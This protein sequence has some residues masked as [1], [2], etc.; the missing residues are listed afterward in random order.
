M[1]PKLKV[2]KPSSN[3]ILKYG[4]KIGKIKDKNKLKD[5]IVDIEL[6]EKKRGK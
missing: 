3:E 2:I 1:K 6:V 5:T 4:S